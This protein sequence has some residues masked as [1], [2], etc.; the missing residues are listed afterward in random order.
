VLVYRSLLLFAGGLFCLSGSLLAE[1][2]MDRARAG[3]QL[4]GDPE[5][6]EERED[7]WTWFGMGYENRTRSSAQSAVDHAADTARGHAGGRGKGKGKK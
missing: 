5:E 4:W 1:P 6:N 7:G 2:E 3:A